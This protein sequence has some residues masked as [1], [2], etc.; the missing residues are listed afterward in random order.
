MTS[1]FEAILHQE[2]HLDSLDT[3]NRVTRTTLTISAPG[4][5]SEYGRGVS[6]SLFD[7]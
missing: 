6:Y 5:H 4:L 2:A 1:Q 7:V 3:C